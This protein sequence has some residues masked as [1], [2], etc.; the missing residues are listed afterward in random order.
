SCLQNTMFIII[1]LLFGYNHHKEL[2]FIPYE[3]CFKTH[4]D[5]LSGH[6]VMY[7]QGQLLR[8]FY[9]SPLLVSPLQ[10]HSMA[11]KHTLSGIGVFQFDE[12]IQIFQCSEVG[13]M[14]T[15]CYVLD[16]SDKN[17]NRN[18]ELPDTVTCFDLEKY[19]F[20][21]CCYDRGM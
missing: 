12:I 15:Q 10:H 8:T 4:K 11:A 9:D 3:P 1:D 19:D 14:F 13:D 21:Y 17:L 5:D 6:P 16:H 2:V 18:Q 20:K 7:G